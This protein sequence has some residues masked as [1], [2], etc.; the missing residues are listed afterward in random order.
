MTTGLVITALTL[1]LRH[2]VDW[3]HIAAIADLSSTARS[4]R[5]GF[6]LSFVYA[7]GHGLVVIALG[8][9]AIAFGSALPEGVDV[10]MGRVVGATLVILGAWIL[11]DLIRSGRDF[12]LRS[13]WIL[14]LGGT[15]AGLRRVRD[16]RRRRR[17]V[18]EHDH[19]HAHTG[20]DQGDSTS[21]NEAPAHEHAHIAQDGEVVIDLVEEPVGVASTPLRQ[22]SATRGIGHRHG[23]GL[24]SHRHAHAHEL[25]LGEY[26][27]AHPGNGTAAGIGLLHGIG[28]ES[29][30]QIAIFVA[31]TSVAGVGGGLLLLLAWVAGLIIANSGLALL[32]AFGLLHAERNFT[33]YATIAVLVAVA[34]LA[35][36]A[37]LIAGL[38]VL[39]AIL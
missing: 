19:D 30:T 29:P 20:A 21:H 24:R 36:G 3:D 31:S 28:F 34:S 7:G 16:A 27:T 37:L 13:R 25:S 14:V 32:A 6:W 5:H 10:W 39:P 18:I 33:I 35:M 22:G 9:L 2:G 26:A 11:V 4:R 17:V 38:D 8:V 1:G 12:R 15:F 23:P